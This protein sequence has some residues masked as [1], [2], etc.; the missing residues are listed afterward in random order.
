MSNV[1]MYH[2]LFISLPVEEHLGCSQ[3]LEITNQA[4]I[5]LCVHVLVQTDV[6]NFSE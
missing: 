5:N 3:V 4:A 2:S 1:C 6:F